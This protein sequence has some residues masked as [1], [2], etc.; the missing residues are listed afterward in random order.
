MRSR[1]PSR[2]PFSTVR[3]R[4]YVCEFVGF[5]VVGLCSWL[6]AGWLQAVPGATNAA[7]CR[8]RLAAGGVPWRNWAPRFVLFFGSFFRL[9]FCLFFARFFARFFYVNLAARGVVL[10]CRAEH[11][12]LLLAHSVFRAA[13]AM[14]HLVLVI[15]FERDESTCC[16]INEV[17]CGSENTG[18]GDLPTE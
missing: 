2:A 9:F 11:I 8:A 15:S 18:C 10:C 13:G 14:S 3:L 1:Y 5:S 7:R 6:V 17:L 4:V 16:R 12:V